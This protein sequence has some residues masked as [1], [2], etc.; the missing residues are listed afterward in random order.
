MSN[1]ARLYQTQGK[2][3]KAEPLFVD[4]LQIQIQALGERHPDTVNTLYNLACLSSLQGHLEEAIDR[5]A[6]AVRRGW[7]RALIFNDSDLFP[8]EG[9]PRFESILAELHAQLDD[10]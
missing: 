5:L 6:D 2:Y 3:D 4:A 8:L 7:A 1:L 9:D 10:G